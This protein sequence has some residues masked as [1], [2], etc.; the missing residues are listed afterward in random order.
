[1][2]IAAG[3]SVHN[4]NMH[5]GSAVRDALSGV[6]GLD[7]NGILLALGYGVSMAR[8]G[9]G[10]IIVY[11]RTS[12][13]AVAYYRRV[14]ANDYTAFIKVGASWEEIQNTSHK[15]VVNG[16]AGLDANGF[17]GSNIT[18]PCK[19]IY[20]N[21][22]G[23]IDNFLQSVTVAGGTV[24]ANAANHRIDL[25]GTTF[26][27]SAYI[28]TKDSYTLGAKPIIISFILQNIAIGGS[29]YGFMGL[30]NS[31]DLNI[32]ND[33]ACA[34]LLYSTPLGGSALFPRCTNGGSLTSGTAFRVY[35]GDVIT[36]VATSAKALYFQNGTLKDTLTSN[37]PTASLTSRFIATR[38]TVNINCGVDMFTLDKYV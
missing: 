16:I 19:E 10:D 23:V 24:T 38:G 7:A 6:A 14:G 25:A 29:S 1:M 30:H 18:Y 21:H 13:E 28:E 4:G 11:E 31:T 5:S 27:D 17:L 22:L 9:S 34:Q 32:P 35:N 12:S 8:D 26:G 2:P 20:Q 33:G 15:D 3:I 37:L 36:I